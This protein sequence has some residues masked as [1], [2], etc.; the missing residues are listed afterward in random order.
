LLSI[1]RKMAKPPEFNFTKA[2]QVVVNL[3]ILEDEYLRAYRSSARTVLAYS[4][5]RRRVSFVANILQ[6]SVT[7][8]RYPRPF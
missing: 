3:N 6:P 4:I 7:R 8:T 1:K 2:K 5:D